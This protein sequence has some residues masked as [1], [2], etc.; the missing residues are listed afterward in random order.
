LSLDEQLLCEQSLLGAVFAPCG[1]WG[2]S[3]R[4]GKGNLVVWPA[5]SKG[6]GPGPETAVDGPRTPRPV[7]LRTSLLILVG[8]DVAVA[9]QVPRVRRSPQTQPLVAFGTDFSGFR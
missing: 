5:P 3:R 4:S 1:R 8:V 2:R 9:P 6:A 7:R